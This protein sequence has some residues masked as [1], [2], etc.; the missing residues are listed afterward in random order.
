[1]LS[2][3]IPAP[4]RRKIIN[5]IIGSVV[6]LATDPA[7]SHIIDACWGATTD[8]KYQRDKIAGEMAGQADIVRNDFFGKQ[9]WRNWNMNTYTTNRND[10]RRPIG[11]QETQYAKMPTVKKKPR[12]QKLN[13]EER[14]HKKSKKSYE[15]KPGIVT[16][17]F[18]AVSG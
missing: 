3:K 11:T 2:S 18:S 1:M 17:H 12:L 8:L 9:V 13:S 6:K 7:G 16:K 4:L 5:H 10:W 15:G 14:Q